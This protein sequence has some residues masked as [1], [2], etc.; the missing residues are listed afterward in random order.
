IYPPFRSQVHM[1]SVWY[2]VVNGTQVGPVSLAEVKAAA[3]TGK[4]APTDLV[5]EEG[6]PDWVAARTISGLFCA[7]P[8]PKPSGSPQP[9]YALSP[10][11]P[12][13]SAALP[14]DPEPLALDDVAPRARA[15]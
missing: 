13:P 8:P 3:D 4:L 15:R 14:L 12:G 10:P 6:T 5:W 7:A 9:T 2:Y 11:T 1:E